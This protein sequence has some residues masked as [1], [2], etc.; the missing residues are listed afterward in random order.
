MQTMNGISPTE[1]L[2]GA[3]SIIIALLALVI[4]YKTLE[5]TDLPKLRIKTF[6]KKMSYSKEEDNVLYLQIENVGSESACQIF[7]FIKM[8]INGEKEY[9][10]TKPGLD[11][12]PN[13]IFN[14]RFFIGHLPDEHYNMEHYVIVQD[15][16][17]V[18][19][20]ME[21]SEQ[22][23]HNKKLESWSTP[24]KKLRFYNCKNLKHKKHLKKAVKSGNTYLGETEKEFN[25]ELEGI[26]KII[27]ND[28]LYNDAQKNRKYP[29]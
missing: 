9:H 2:I 4:S 17:G 7:F 13:E 27:T 28:E 18:K 10:V 23:A 25:D 29:K 11:L 8:E 12:K 14:S 6:N 5:S 15:Y 20:Y 21:I 19:Y 26:A 3:I 22:E 1:I 24:I 16:S